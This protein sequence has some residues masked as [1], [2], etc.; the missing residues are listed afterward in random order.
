MLLHVSILRSS[1]GSMYCSLLK[2]CVNKIDTLLYVS[3]MQQHIVCLCICC[4]PRREFGQLTSLQGI[5]LIHKHTICC[6]ITETYNNVTWC[7]SDRASWI[8]YTLITNLM[9]WLLVIHKL[10][11]SSTCFEHQML[12]FRRTQLYTCSIWYRHSL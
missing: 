8:D 10:L 11:F 5:Q 2:L 3:V 6:C 4:T 7:F 1:S 9:H 12:I